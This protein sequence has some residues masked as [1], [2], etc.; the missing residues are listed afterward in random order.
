M[1][2]LYNMEMQEAIKILSLNN[3]ESEIIYKTDKNVFEEN[4]F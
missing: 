2:C 3:N 4:C 1:I